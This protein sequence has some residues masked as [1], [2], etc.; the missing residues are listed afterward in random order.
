MFLGST[1]V[2]CGISTCVGYTDETLEA[3]ILESR[4]LDLFVFGEDF[5]T[6]FQSVER[7]VAEILEFLGNAAV[8]P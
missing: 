4:F 8:V 2:A 1:G 6:T 3:S 7:P 5:L